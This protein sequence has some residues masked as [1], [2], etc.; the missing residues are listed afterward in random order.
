LQD[1]LQHVSGKVHRL[2]EENLAYALIGEGDLERGA[3]LLEDLIRSSISG[4]GGGGGQGEISLSDIKIPAMSEWLGWQDVV[5]ASPTD[6]QEFLQ[7]AL[8]RAKEERDP[9]RIIGLILE[10]LGEQAR[11]QERYAEWWHSLPRDTSE[12]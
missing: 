6:T 4:S 1:A 3:S 5:Y 9:P 2:C 12:S 11:L 7:E 10:L 8:R